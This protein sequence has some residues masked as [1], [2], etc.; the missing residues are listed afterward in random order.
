LSGLATT[1]DLDL[2]ANA[3]DVTTGL[4]TKVDKITGKGLSSTDFTQVE[5]DKLALITGTNTGD[6]DLSS[7]ATKAELENDYAKLDE[8]NS[9]SEDQ[10]FEGRIKFGDDANSNIRV[11]NYSNEEDEE[12]LEGFLISNDEVIFL[13]KANDDRQQVEGWAFDVEE[14]TL[15]FP[16]NAVVM[17][18]DGNVFYITSENDLFLTSG[19]GNDEGKWGEIGMS[20]YERLYLEIFNLESGQEAGISLIHEDGDEIPMEVKIYNS[21]N[22]WNFGPSG[23]LVFPFNSEIGDNDERF[24][25]SSDNNIDLYS[26][27]IVYITGE[28][29][30]DIDSEGDI[31]IDSEEEIKIHSEDYIRIV[32]A[33][34]DEE[35]EEDGYIN[36]NSGIE[37]DY[38]D[39]IEL[40]IRDNGEDLEWIFETDGT[41]TFP[42]NTRLGDS[43]G[44]FRIRSPNALVLMGDLDDEDVGPSI[45]ISPPISFF[46][47]FMDVED[48]E[49][50]IFITTANFDENIQEYV[51]N[52]WKFGESGNLV[53][54]DGTFFG[55]VEGPGTIGFVTEEDS[56]FIL[57]TRNDDD[58]SFDWQFTKDG[59]FK[60]PDGGDIQDSNG[61]SVLG[62]NSFR[63]KS[64]VFYI[65]WQI[66]YDDDT[67]N[68]TYSPD[69]GKGIEDDFLHKID[70]EDDDWETGFKLIFELEEEPLDPEK[71]TIYFNGIRIPRKLFLPDQDTPFLL[72]PEYSYSFPDVNNPNKVSI[73]IFSSPNELL[74]FEFFGPTLTIT[75]DYQY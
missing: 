57:R 8:E 16:G 74:I 25:I 39:G 19:I 35:D 34:G 75:I 7:L 56:D 69:F 40:F 14:G 26:D 70:E 66:N 1:I 5:K 48:T 4:S 73:D 61:N 2:K 27:E 20:S 50:N 3:V 62:P 45:A 6:Q 30:V 49:G 63:F 53:F 15:K 29:E 21:E 23:T 52:S 24:F 10:I 18:Q 43:E 44:T 12:T 9:F 64:E 58:D 28:E 11:L 51:L 41:L 13:G 32:S 68:T 72:V 59:V 71:L 38:E 60:L 46:S 33:D 55:K 42:D 47:E 54:P 17:G 65:D 67:N 36:Y 37:L 22:S 31:D